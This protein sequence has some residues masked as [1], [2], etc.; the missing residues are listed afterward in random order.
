MAPTP[1]T[2]T[3]ML[4]VAVAAEMVYQLIGANLS[5]P[6]SNQLNAGARAPTL[7]KWVNLTNIEAVAWIAFLAYL[8]QSW[9]PVLGGTLALGSMALKYKNAIETGLAE[10]LP[11]TEDYQHPERMSVNAV[12]EYSQA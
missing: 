2:A 12:Y 11:P 6:Q 3:R 1:L 8:D 9:W 5:S 10:R 7:Q 4:T